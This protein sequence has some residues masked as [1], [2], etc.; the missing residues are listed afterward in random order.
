MYVFISS[1]TMVQELILCQS[2]CLWLSLKLTRSASVVKINCGK[3]SIPVVFRQCIFYYQSMGIDRAPAN[4][5]CL[6]INDHNN[7]EAKLVWWWRWWGTLKN[8][9]INKKCVT[10]ASKWPISCNTFVWFRE[11]QR[12]S[13]QLF[14][15]IDFFKANWGDHMLDSIK[16]ADH[17]FTWSEAISHRLAKHKVPTTWRGNASMLILTS[18]LDICLLQIFRGTS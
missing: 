2:L 7:E 8:N 14:T 11:I 5:I 12:I 6:R 9:L 4:Y 10:D 18:F 15:W 3:Q 1:T 16:Y 13:G 17:C